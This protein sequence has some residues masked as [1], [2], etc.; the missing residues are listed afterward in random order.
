MGINKR[1]FP[2][3]TELRKSNSIEFK[4]FIP[5]TRNKNIKISDTAFR[6]RI[7][8]A[9]FFFSKRFGGSTF[10]VETGTYQLKNKTIKER[11]SVITIS[12]RPSVYNKYDEEVE[13]WLRA[14]KKSWQQDSM[15][16]IYQG[17]MVFV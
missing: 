11:V 17:K 8:D 6:K 5:S 1:D 10:A 2:N 3:K 4:V 15:G 16:F 14:K 7:D 12:A 13:A 9:V